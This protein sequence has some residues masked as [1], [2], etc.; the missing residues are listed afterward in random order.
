[1]NLRNQPDHREKH[2]SSFSLPAATG[3]GQVIAT[4]LRDAGME[5]HIDHLS[6]VE[7]EVIE[8]MSVIT[9][10]D[11]TDREILEIYE[12]VLPLLTHNP[13]NSNI[14]ARLNSHI[15][16][17]VKYDF[18]HYSM[19]VPPEDADDKR[20]NATIL[21]IKGWP[22]KSEESDEAKEVTI[23]VLDRQEREDDFSSV[24]EK[25]YQRM[26]DGHIEKFPKE[27]EFFY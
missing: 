7:K 3:G 6:N 23:S 25:I 13:E 1:M 18:Y 17:F 19:D 22:T 9:R 24:V 27:S 14:P 8:S 5:V 16:R 11:I 21:N 20:L 26:I 2:P 12:D 4:A 15:L 10:P